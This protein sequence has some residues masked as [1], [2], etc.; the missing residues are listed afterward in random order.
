ME[1][2]QDKVTI[3]FDNAPNGL[4]SKD[5]NITEIYIAGDDKIFYPAEAQIQ[6]D[7]PR[8]NANR[9]ESKKYS[10]SCSFA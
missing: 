6:N 5:K 4:I 7:G 10:D 9:R 1:V 8:I 3:L 2:Q